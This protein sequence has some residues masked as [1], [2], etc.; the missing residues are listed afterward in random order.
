MSDFKASLQ[1][2]EEKQKALEAEKQQLR[3]QAINEVQRLIT[4]F[5][6]KAED[7]SFEGSKIIVR[8]KP[9]KIKYRMPNGVTWTGKGNPK[10]AILEYLKSVGESLKDLDKYKVQDEK[11]K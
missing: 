6:I 7:L 2:L 9:S 10:K 3:Y 11:T 5:N 4:Q 8:R 1:E